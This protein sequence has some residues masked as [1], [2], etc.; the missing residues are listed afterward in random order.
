MQIRQALEKDIPGITALGDRF[1]VEIPT[2][3]QVARTLEQNSKLDRQ[4]IWVAEENN[5]LIGYALW[6]PY[7][8]GKGCVFN[9]NDKV[10]ALDEIYLIPEARGQ[11]L[12][13]ELIEAVNA[14][15][16]KEGYTK[17]IVYS[18][19]KDLIPIIRFYKSSGFKTWNVQLFK[20]VK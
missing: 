11:G 2:W 15:A 19:V 17:L 7:D 20:D 13:G 14:Y 4:L 6:L 3:G 12:G 8:K 9:E 1:T 18:S 10:L 5:K 16:K